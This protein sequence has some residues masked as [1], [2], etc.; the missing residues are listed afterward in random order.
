MTRHRVPISVLAVVGAVLG[1][2]LGFLLA[3]HANR[4]TASANVALL[5]PPN[6]TT[7]DSSNFWEVLTRGQVSRTAAVVYDDPRWLTSA[8]SAARVPQ[9][10]LALTAA[11]LPETTMVS[12]T[13]QAGSPAAAEAALND[14]LTNA[15][16]EVTSLTVP[17]VIRV[18]WPPENNAVR[19]ALPGPSQVVAAGALGGLLIGGGIGWLLARRGRDDT[20]AIGHPV[21]GA[22][23]D[24]APLRL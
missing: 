21:A 4:Y 18:V 5:P 24:E 15:T 8:A 16:P 13:V 7:V 14:V 11:A 20:G 9:D 17:Y 12:I 10:E 2:G 1:A 3:P 23:D 6:L 22:A 19:V